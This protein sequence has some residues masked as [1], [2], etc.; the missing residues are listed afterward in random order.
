MTIC[1]VGIFNDEK[2]GNVSEN[3]LW[4]FTLETIIEQVHK[5]CQR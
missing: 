5:M 1:L 2:L 3:V 4:K